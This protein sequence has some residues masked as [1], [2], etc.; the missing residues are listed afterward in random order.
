LVVA[1]GALVPVLLVGGCSLFPSL[2]G[3]SGV[4][5]AA[6][7]EDA[8][9]PLDAPALGEADA[10]A[11]P[12]PSRCSATTGLLCDGFESGSP[13]P[14]WSR[15]VDPQGSLAV[16]S[17]RAYRGTH[18]LHVHTDAIGAGAP[19]LTSRLVESET[20]P[21]T[22]T[23]FVRAFVFLSAAPPEGSSV[24]LIDTSGAKTSGGVEFGASGGRVFVNDFF[25]PTSFATSTSTIFP[26]NRWVCLETQIDQ[27]S[28]RGTVRVLLDGTEV[29]DA[30]LTNATLAPLGNLSIGLDFYQPPALPAFDAWFDEVIVAAEPT[31]CDQ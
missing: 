13:D 22:P 3:F 25:Q 20:F 5:G 28:A 26:L 29:T 27:G 16:D 30:R 23:F 7:L 11:A 18:S 1:E 19:S 8:A 21:V 31:T 6:P 4:D 24:H 17:T 9:A 12:P 2:E 15:S 14:R 10:P